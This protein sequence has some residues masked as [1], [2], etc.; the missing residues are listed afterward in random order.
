MHAPRCASKAAS[1]ALSRPADNRTA[2]EEGD[3]IPDSVRSLKPQAQGPTP[4]AQRLESGPHLRLARSCRPTEHDVGNPRL[5]R[6]S[7]IMC[8]EHPHL[9]QLQII[10]SR[11]L[12]RG[13]PP[14]TASTAPG[15]AL[16][17]V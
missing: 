2:D 5:R 8:A 3:D 14:L 12:L 17:T 4:R 13:A 16:G 15:T 1:T 11:F 10:G 9:V 7:I 6:S